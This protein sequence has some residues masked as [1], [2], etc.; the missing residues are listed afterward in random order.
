MTTATKL[1]LL[2]TKFTFLETIRVPIAVIGTLVFPAL[3]FLFFVVPMREVAE[4]RAY[5]TVATLGLAYFAVMANCLFTFGV[6]AAEDRERPWDPYLRTLP[7]G[8]GPRMTARLLNGLLWSLL[9]LVP[10]L[11]ISLVATEASVSLP[12]LLLCGLLLAVGVLPFLF[13]GLAMGYL[14]PTK[15]ALAVAQVLMFSMAFAGGLFLPPS[16][17]PS[18]LDAGSRVLP[19]RAGRDLLEWGALGGTLSPLTVLVVAA[20]TAATI[21]LAVWAYRRDEGLRFR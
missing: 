21:S 12:R 16:M 15:A 5:A 7:V 8:P 13:G 9:A 1:T 2:H 19:S 20:W 14:L 18:W 6:G 10:V 17:F 3:S 11:T 4:N